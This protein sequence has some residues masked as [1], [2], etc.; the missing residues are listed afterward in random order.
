M[1]KT[2]L[3]AAVLVMA[4]SGLAHAGGQSGSL[5]VGAEFQIVNAN[6]FGIAVPVGGASVNYDAGDFHA[7]GFF[8]FADPDGPDN[9]AYSLGGR[10][11]YHVHSTAMS[12]FG[13]GGS[14]GML[15]LHNPPGMNNTDTFV[16]L[17][18]GIQIRLFLASNV[19]ISASTGIVI[20][21]ADA[22][23]VGLTGQTFAGGIHYYF[24]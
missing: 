1:S 17:E 22:S 9:T 21:T 16:F 18:P 5:G 11:Y 6:V 8:G 14:I 24:F 2:S 4:A 23:G 10:F 3:F 7:G 19:A 12:D 15:H 13:V 20:G